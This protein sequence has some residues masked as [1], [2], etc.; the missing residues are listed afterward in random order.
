MHILDTN[1]I[2]ILERRSPE[3][4]QLLGRLAAIPTQEIR[5]T[6]ISYEEQI[7]GWMAAIGAT[8]NSAVQVLQY[9]RLLA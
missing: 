2:S 6:V 8:K 5:V 7:R 4:D 1:Y 9:E 3:A